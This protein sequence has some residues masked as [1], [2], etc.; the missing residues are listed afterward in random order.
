MPVSTINLNTTYITYV[1]WFFFQFAM[2]ETVLTGCM[3][4]LPYLRPKKT[5]VI[6]VICFAFFLLGLPLTCSVSNLSLTRVPLPHLPHL[7]H[8]LR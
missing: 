1:V 5:L 3:D 4:Q 2:V 6:L 8:V 7:P